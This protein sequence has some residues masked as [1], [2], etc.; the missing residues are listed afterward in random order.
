MTVFLSQFSHIKLL[1]DLFHLFVELLV[2]PIILNSS[3]IKLLLHASLSDSFICKI[4]KLG[5][6]SIRDFALSAP[7]YFQYVKS[8]LLALL[9]FLKDLLLNVTVF[10]LKSEFSMCIKLYI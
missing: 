7:Q 1:A 4:I 9:D 6:L 2:K 8:L 10:D 3:F 5:N